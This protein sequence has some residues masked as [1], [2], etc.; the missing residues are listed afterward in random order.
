MNNCRN[1]ANDLSAF[2]DNE[3]MPVRQTEVLAHVDACP[4]CR[5]RVA[6]LRRQAAGIAVLPAAQ[7]P[8]QF[9]ADVRRKLRQSEPSWVDTLFRPVWWKVP[10]EAMAAIL[11]VAGIVA[12]LQPAAPARVEHAKVGEPNQVPPRT[13][14]ILADEQTKDVAQKVEL[15][16]LTLDPAGQDLGTV[17]GKPNEP[18]LASDGR[19]ELPETM[20]I[21]GDSVVAVRL[22]VETLA[23]QLDGR[24]ESGR[25]TNEFLVYLPQSRV[26]AF[27][28]QVTGSRKTVSYAAPSQAD[29]VVGVKVIVEP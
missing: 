12:L 6:E 18:V 13:A 24:V 11:I 17:G 4:Q 15:K 27:R 9:L 14:R 20:R 16:P 3:L 1:I 8:P 7:P 29:P 23:K 10:L 22:R 5:E 19:P 28:S 25:P 21:R 2:I 26:A